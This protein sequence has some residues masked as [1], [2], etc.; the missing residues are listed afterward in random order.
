MVRVEDG[1]SGGEA[2]RGEERWHD[3]APK[4]ALNL[5]ASELDV[6]EKIVSDLR[7]AYGAP[8]DPAWRRCKA[9]STPEINSA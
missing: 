8:P 4:I 5:L 9:A 7:E 2:R 6:G 3:C 1:G